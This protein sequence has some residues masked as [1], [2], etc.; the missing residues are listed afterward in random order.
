LLIAVPLVAVLAWLAWGHMQRFGQLGLIVP[1]VGTTKDN[2]VTT[3]SPK[4]G[5]EE[6][7]GPLDLQAH[8]SF[9]W[10][11]RCDRGCPTTTSTTPSYDCNAGFTNWK[12][13]WSRIKKRWCCEHKQRGCTGTEVEFD[14]NAA[15]NNLEKAWSPKK[16]H[17]CCQ[18]AQRGC[19]PPSARDRPPPLSSGGLTASTPCN[20][21]CS[22]NGYSSTCQG[23]ITFAARKYYSGK[24]DACMQ[25]RTLLVKFCPGCSSCPLDKGCMASFE[26][27]LTMVQ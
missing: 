20:A 21:P 23:H 14:C 2:P 1:G 19:P 7:S 5:T 25:A 13:G 8:S 26:P 22:F 11:A 12:R 15:L 24:S 17:W 10:C 16:K 18:H 27:K 4:E 3:F 6:C 9:W